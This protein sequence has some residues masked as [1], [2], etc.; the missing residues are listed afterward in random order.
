MKTVIIG[1]GQLGLYLF[2]HLRIDG[3]IDIVDYPDFSITDPEKVRNLVSRY[4]VII[5]AAAYTNVDKAES[6][7]V[8][9][10][11]VNSFGPIL[12]SQ[13]MLKHP[14]KKLVHISSEVVYGSND[15][16]YQSLKEEDDK[17]PTCVYA[18]SKKLADDYI[19]NL[20]SIGVS[21]I[22]LL[23]SGWLFGPDN[24]HNF[25]EKIRRLLLE[26]ETLNVVSDQVGTLTHVSL[27]QYAIEDH[28]N[29][30]LPAD[31]YNIGN[32]GFVSRYEIACYMKELI[33]S[34]CRISHCSS[35][36]YPRAANVA[37]NSKLN[38]SKL[39]KFI[40]F[41]RVDWRKDVERT[42]KGD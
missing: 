3:L 8:S 23:R 39:D 19:E 27:I 2:R 22:L 1:A 17:H 42:L 37:K 33:G 38:C 24:D 30:R 35:K 10:I 31:A 11:S 16:Y 9:C 12:L 34:N 40:S 28:L 13:E 41:N 29:G 25:I 32:S 18:L 20:Y 7:R 26:K 4:D 5:N 6:D 36:E 14:E 21:N 15:P